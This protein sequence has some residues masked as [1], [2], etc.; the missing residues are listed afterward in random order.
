MVLLVIKCV[1]LLKVLLQMEQVS[2]LEDKIKKQSAQYS[3]SQH[4]F[5]LTSTGASEQF[6]HFFETLT[7]LTSGLKVDSSVS[8]SSFVIFFC[9]SNFSK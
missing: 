5:N 1:A 9:L 8:I 6:E 3:W 7:S 2:P 4:S